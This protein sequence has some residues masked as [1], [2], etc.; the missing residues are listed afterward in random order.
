[1]TRQDSKIETQLDEGQSVRLTV[2]T[3]YPDSGRVKVIV[4]QGP[5]FEWTISLRVP[6]WA[7]GATL[8]RADQTSQVA[9]GYVQVT[10]PFQPGETLQLDLP[11]QARW[12][13]PDQ[14]IDGTRGCVAV[15]R[16]PIV[17][18]LESVDLGADTGSILVDTDRPPV[19]DGE[20]VR[21]PLSLLEAGDPA[22]PYAGDG[23]RR[24]EAAQ[25][26]RLIPYHDWGNR[27]PSTM[28]VW[29]PVV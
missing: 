12:T 29:L 6:A 28:R 4:D 19:D 24:S 2:L 25:L 23:P 13:F 11:L 22:W 18:A 21:V 5:D 9:A 16:G 3:G 8:T 15:E 1:M 14:R 7:D 20:Q 17:M 10:G 26:V 27:G